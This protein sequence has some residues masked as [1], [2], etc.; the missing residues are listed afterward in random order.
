MPEVSVIIP[1]R[2]RAGMLRYS[3]QRLFAQDLEEGSFEIIVID[4]ASEDDT[5]DI[6][7]QT[8]P[9][10]RDLVYQKQKT[11]TSAGAARNVAIALA[12]APLLVFLDDDALVGVSFLR[13]H[14]DAHRRLNAKVVTGPIIEITDPTE[15]EDG[16]S[17]LGSGWHRNPFPSGNVSV[18][19]DA[20]RAV[21]G[22]DEQFQAY[23]WEDP[24]LYRRLEK[25]GLGR[26]FDPD[27]AIFHCKPLSVRNDFVARLRRERERGAMGALFYA[28]HPSFGVGVMTKAHPL[29][30]GIDALLAP[31]LRLEERTELALSKG[32]VPGS[33][34]WRLL[35]ANHVEIK[36]A[37]EAW[38]AMGPAYRRALASRASTLP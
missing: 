33:A 12:K 36:S 19:A 5:S 29:I 26:H 10:F 32:V 28:K 11:K 14:R 8:K 23:G 17:R 9:Y 3:L 27:A 30:S 24:E 37:R 31:L 7:E 2:N 13:R 6:V 15:A 1:T 18:A 35:I 22:F 38:V 4:D 25:R 34:I 21:G 20:V 16:N